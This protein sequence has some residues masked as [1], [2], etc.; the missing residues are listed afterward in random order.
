MSKQSDNQDST[1]RESSLPYGS[2]TNSHQGDIDCSLLDEA[3]AM[4]PWE[5]MLAN[6]EVVNFGESLRAAMMKRHAKPNNSTGI[7]RDTETTGT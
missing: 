5:R 3:L 2:P 6:D 4:T 1:L 7:E